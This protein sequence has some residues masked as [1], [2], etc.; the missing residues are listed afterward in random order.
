MSNNTRSVL[1]TRA[2][3]FSS[4]SIPPRRHPTPTPTPTPPFPRQHLPNASAAASV[5]LLASDVSPSLQAAHSRSNTESTVATA[6]PS[7]AP[8][9]APAPPLATGAAA[10][11]GGPERTGSGPTAPTRPTA[12]HA[13]MCSRETG[14]PIAAATDERAE[15]RASSD[16]AAHARAPEGGGGG[17]GGEPSLDLA[18]GAAAAA[19]LAAASRA[20]MAPRAH[21]APWALLTAL[22]VKPTAPGMVHGFGGGGGGGGGEADNK[23]GG[24]GWGGRRGSARTSTDAHGAIATDEGASSGESK[25]HTEGTTGNRKRL[26]KTPKLFR[27][28]HA[29]RLVSPCHRREK[30]T[31]DL[32]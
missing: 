6:L 18:D 20:K 10:A 5:L 4:S 30:P 16:R 24:E 14:W 29:D 15:G 27:C 1:R 31:V 13:A 22:L 28:T 21:A 23:R 2:E 9:P 7:S 11:G 19:I 32:T 8:P 12:S 26:V 25:A 17:R 3:A